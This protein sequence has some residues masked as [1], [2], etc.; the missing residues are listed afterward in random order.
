MF[1]SR[2]DRRRKRAGYSVGHDQASRQFQTF[3][4]RSAKTKPINHHQ[5]S[6]SPVRRR[7]ISFA[8]KRNWQSAAIIIGL[9]GGLISIPKSAIEG[10]HAL[11]R[12]PHVEVSPNQPIV[13]TY[14]QKLKNLEGSTGVLVYNSGDKAEIIT[15][16]D[17]HLGAADNPS[18]GVAFSGNDIIL[19]DGGLEISSVLAAENSSKSL[20]CEF[21]IPLSEST[22]GLFTQQPN[23]R[24]FVLELVSKD[25]SHRYPATFH[26]N[27][28]EGLLEELVDPQRPGKIKLVDSVQ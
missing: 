4:L 18:G 17:A 25:G 10:W 6:K 16:H 13:L 7:P 23:R 15:P 21:T 19:K 26:F 28:S 14:N 5:Q 11:F 9:V 20:A 2:L 22:K 12:Q 27:L 3:D 8:M 1:K 24:E